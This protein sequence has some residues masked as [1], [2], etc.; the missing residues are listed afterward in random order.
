MIRRQVG[1]HAGRELVREFSHIA[2][3]K[4]NI[5]TVA[6]YVRGMYAARVVG[7]IP[8]EID[9]DIKSRGMTYRSRDETGE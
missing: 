7:R 6:K 1:W 9:D 8:E 5:V 3:R 2:P 4:F